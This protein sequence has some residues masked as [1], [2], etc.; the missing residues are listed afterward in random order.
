MTSAGPPGGPRPSYG[1]PQRFQGPPPPGS[2]PMGA[3]PPYAGAPQ[4]GAGPMMV[5]QAP[6]GSR[7][8]QGQMVNLPHRQSTGTK[9]YTK[10]ANQNGIHSVFLGPHFFVE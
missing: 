2:V 9:F 6:P 8:Q 5:G 10:P 7:P 3:R 1:S 4:P